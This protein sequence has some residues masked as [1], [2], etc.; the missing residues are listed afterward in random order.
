MKYLRSSGIIVGDLKP[1]NLLIDDR[2]GVRIGPVIE[3]WNYNN[4]GEFDVLGA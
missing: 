1:G 3:Q 2:L 4:S